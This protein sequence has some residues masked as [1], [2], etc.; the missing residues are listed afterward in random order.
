MMAWLAPALGLVLTLAGSETG[1]TVF[2]A[3]AGPSAPDPSKVDRAKAL[4]SKVDP[5]KAGAP[6]SES[7]EQPMDPSVSR[8]KAAL[9]S[10]WRYPWYDG[11]EDRA[12]PVGV[13]APWR[14][15]A[16]SRQTS[17]GTNIDWL[18]LVIWVGGFLL[19]ALI[20]YLC[21]L[22]YL[23]R[24]DVATK[25]DGQLAN[26]ME[27]SDAARIEA[28]PAKV[29]WGV[30]DLLAEAR[31]QYE[32]GN[33]REAIIYLFSHQL[34]HMDRQQIIRLGKG[35]TNRQYL[36]ELGPRA[37]LRRLVEQTM[38]AFEDVFFGNYELD[39]VRFEACWH[40]LDEFTALASQGAT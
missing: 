1:A 25:V 37:M 39:R 12:R 17:G 5:S 11:T 26:S 19:L 2:L 14:W 32:Q 18:E 6:S 9:R 40:R 23:R 13:K 20:T 29:R 36:R 10:K 4:P 27:L 30:D 31:R 15:P 24:E 22:A 38:C 16:R 33:Y 7:A 8:A 34:V 28:L 35:K 21:I 3:V